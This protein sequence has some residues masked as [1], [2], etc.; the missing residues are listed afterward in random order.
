MN[1]IR[2]A[3]AEEAEVISSLAI[4][5]KAHWGYTPEQMVVFSRELVLSPAELATR[6]AHVLEENGRIIGLYTLVARADDAAELDHLFIDPSRL[7]SGLGAALFRHACVVAQQ[8]G[9]RRLSI[10]SDPH[11][12]GFYA[13]MGARLEGYVPSSI[14]GRQL[15]VF[16]LDL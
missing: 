1:R 15:P 13:A 11:A 7:G 9:F 3:I 5:S 16:T 2:P 6:R 12:V 4:R 14:P 10:L 8:A